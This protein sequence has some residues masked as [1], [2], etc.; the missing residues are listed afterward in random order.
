MWIQ[1][2]YESLLLSPPQALQLFPV[3]LFLGPRQVGKSSLLRRVAGPERLVVNLDDLQTRG[4]AHRDP[5]LFSAEMRC[6]VLLDEIQYAPQLLDVIKR[7]VDD[8]VAPGAFWLTGSQNFEVMRGVRETLAGRVAM[9]N[10]LG[11]S[12]EEL[13]GGPMD[14][15]AYFARLLASSF[16]KLAGVQDAAA[17]DLYLSSY[18]QTYVERDVRELLGIQKRREFEVFVRMCAL[19]TG[20]VVNCADLARDAGISP[21]TAREWLSLLEDSFLIRLVH[22]WHANANKRL[23]KSPKLYFLDAGLAAWLAGWRTVD[24]ARLGPMAGAL[25]ETHLFGQILRRFRHRAREVAIHFW[26]TREGQEI[27]FLVE[28]GGRVFPIEVKAGLPD[29]RDLPRLET[30]RGPQWEPGAVLSLVVDRATTLREDWQAR[31]CAD[32]SFLPVDG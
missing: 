10:L 7:R 31:S 14:P 23:V 2:T 29:A 21:V 32:L 18:L 5:V 30:I 28:T 19:R 9:L 26:R 17:R 13:G 12:D 4:R 15:P 6:P 24:Q 1:R 11:L 8:G 3:W 25:L 20:Q 16:P 27:D 22:P